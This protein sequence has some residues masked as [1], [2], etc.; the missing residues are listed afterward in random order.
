MDDVVFE[1]SK[2]VKLD[3]P[4]SEV[5]IKPKTAASQL[6][7]AGVKKDTLIT[8]EPGQQNVPSSKPS[9]PK[10][11]L[12]PTKKKVLEMKPFFPR[13]QIYGRRD[14]VDEKDVVR[15]ILDLL[16]GAN[17]PLDKNIN[18]N[19]IAAIVQDQLRVGDSKKVVEALD[20]LVSLHRMFADD[21][22][23]EKHFDTFVAPLLDSF[24]SEDAFVRK[25]VINCLVDMGVR[26][27]NALT[28]LICALNERDKTIVQSAI[29][30]L[31]NYGIADKEGL[32]RGMVELGMMKGANI[33]SNNESLEVKG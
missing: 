22:N 21:V 10:K 1:P 27:D 4:V 11:P 12:S 18:I 14:S 19:S 33:F 3:S 7:S 9:S 15:P 17:A 25:K 32:K 28:L 5:K 31:A 29:K 23:Q 16:S 2:Y 6:R 20:A 24:L 8:F 30:G 13:G 26:H